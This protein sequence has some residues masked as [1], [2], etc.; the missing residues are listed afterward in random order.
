MSKINGIGLKRINVLLFENYKKLHGDLLVPAKFIVPVDP[1][2]PK[3]A[4]NV[5]LGNYI[6]R[7]RDAEKHRLKTNEPLYEPED[8][9]KLM[10]LGLELDLNKFNANEILKAFTTYKELFNKTEIEKDFKI[11][12]NSDVWPK[13][14]AG[15]NLFNQ[16]CEFIVNICF[17]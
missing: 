11:P 9:N 12:A 6:A 5:K 3:E 8:V 16:L 15:R 2:W 13:S 1:K 17:F 4:H 10:K 7:V 14:L